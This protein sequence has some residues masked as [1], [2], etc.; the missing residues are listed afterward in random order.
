MKINVKFRFA[1]VL[2]LGGDTS[3]LPPEDLIS[4]AADADWRIR[5]AVAQAGASRGLTAQLLDA[6]IGTLGAA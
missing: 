3:K 2:T 4:A 5:Q 6:I 1:A